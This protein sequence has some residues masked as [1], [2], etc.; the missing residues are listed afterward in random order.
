MTII[1]NDWSGLFAE[2]ESKFSES[3]R[4]ALNGEIALQLQDSALSN[5]GGEMASGDMR[6]WNQEQLLSPAY[7]RLVRREFA[8]LVRTEEERDRTKG[9]KWEGGT[10]AHLKDNFSLAYDAN[11]ATLRN[12]S[13]Y[14]SNHQNGEGVPRRPFFPVDEAGNLMPF[15]WERIRVILDVHF[16]V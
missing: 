11:S 14:A 9:T 3:G 12:N 5:F 10:G 2:L 4:A 6:P 8:T 7:S 16:Q 15:M 1:Q 13:D